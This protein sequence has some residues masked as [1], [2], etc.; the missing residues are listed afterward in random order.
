MQCAS[1]RVCMQWL[2]HAITH[3]A[4]C[5]PSH[6]CAC[7][8][9]ALGAKHEALHKFALYCNVLL[10]GSVLQCLAV[11][12]SVWQCVAVCCSVL[13]GVRV[14]CSRG[15]S[16]AFL[17]MTPL[18]MCMRQRGHVGGARG[19]GR[20]EDKD[21]RDSEGKGEGARKDGE[22]REKGWRGER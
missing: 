8:C 10:C 17:L 13:Q 14:C 6:H 2:M 18:H 5:M 22:K 7:S 4:S 16:P 21:E 12:G 3:N 19:G 1:G 11:C 15:V 20:E 9:L